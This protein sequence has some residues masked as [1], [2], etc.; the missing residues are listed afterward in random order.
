MAKAFRYLPLLIALG[1]SSQ[2]QVITSTNTSYAL[3]NKTATAYTTADK[4]DLRL[5][6]TGTLNFTDFPQPME[7]QPCVF[8]DPTHQFQ[9]LLG[10]GGAI[11]DASAETFAKLPKASQEEFLKAYYDPNQGIGYTLA[12]TNIN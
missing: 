1:C 2:K 9:T 8:V 7:T 12:R 10:I 3:D 5:T 11:T 6:A 4:T